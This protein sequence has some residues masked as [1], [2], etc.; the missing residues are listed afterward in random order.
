[1]QSRV[2]GEEGACCS[3]LGS[4]QWGEKGVVKGRVRGG[5]EGAGLSCLGSLQ[6][7]RGG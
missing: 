7:R 1:M 2:R 5:G 4:L 3:C 6:W